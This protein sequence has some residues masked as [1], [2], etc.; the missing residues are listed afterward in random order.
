[1]M[2]VVMTWCGGN[3]DDADTGVEDSCNAVIQ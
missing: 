1:V 2:M 3:D